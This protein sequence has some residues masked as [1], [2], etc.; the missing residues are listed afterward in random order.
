MSGVSQ[1]GGGGDRYESR[2]V[3]R[4]QVFVFS[5][6]FVLSVAALVGG[7]SWWG[8]TR[9]GF[10]ARPRALQMPWNTELMPQPRLQIDPAGDLMQLRA[11]KDR[12][13]G[14]TGWIDRAHGIAHIPI[15]RAMAIEAAGG[16]PGR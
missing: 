13:L 2:D 6:A 4:R 5:I 3:S 11:S 10:D 12:Q 9:W 1:S 7:L 16:G 8:A 15:D 14:S